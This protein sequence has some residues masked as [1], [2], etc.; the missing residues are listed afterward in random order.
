MTNISIIENKISSVKKYLKTVERYQKY[1]QEDME[2]SVD[3]RSMIERQLYLVAQST[4]DLAEAYISYR[5]LRKPTTMTDAFYILEEE[6]LISKDLV[7]R[8]VG[9]V[10]FR[11]ILS[12]DYEKIDYAIVYDILRSGLRDIKE[13]LKVFSHI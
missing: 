8:M 7:K 5:N 4:I 6:G 9:M 3:I 2:N 12:H 1:T 13:F 11:N 10:G